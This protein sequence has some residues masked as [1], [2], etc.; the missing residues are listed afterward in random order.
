MNHGEH[1]RDPC[2]VVGMGGQGSI[3]GNQVE[4]QTCYQYLKTKFYY[5]KH[6]TPTTNY[7]R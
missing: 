6:E 5:D 7:I 1:Y 2:I 4:I 3:R